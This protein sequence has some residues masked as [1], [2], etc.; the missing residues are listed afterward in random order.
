[1]DKFFVPPNTDF[2]DLLP[3]IGDHMELNIFP[4]W[5]MRDVDFLIEEWNSAIAIQRTRVTQTEDIFGGGIR[6]W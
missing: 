2:E 4:Q 6:F 3:E 1:M 5:D